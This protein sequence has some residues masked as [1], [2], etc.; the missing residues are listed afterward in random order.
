MFKRSLYFIIGFLALSAP[1]AVAAMAPIVSSDRILVIA[2]HPDD[3]MLGAGGLMQQAVAAGADLRVL[4]MTNGELNE[5]ASIFY[6]KRPLLIRS[7]FIKNGVIR[8]KEAVDALNFLGVPLDKLIFLGYPDG[9]TLNIWIKYW[10]NSKPFRSFFTRINKVPFKDNISYGRSYKGDEIIHDLERVLLDLRPTHIYVTGPFDL[11]T[12]HQAAYLYVHVAVLNLSDMLVPSP[13]IHL[14]VVHAHQ[15]PQPKKYVPDEPMAI[16][17]HIDWS[18]A[19]RWDSVLLESK[20]VEKKKDALLKYK[21]QTAY[22]KKFLLSF[23]RKSEVFA[24]YSHEVVARSAGVLTDVQVFDERS[25]T[26]DVRYKISG[27]ELW[28]EIPLTSAV[29]EMGVLS[30]YIFSYRKGFLFSEMPKLSFKLFGN[31][32]FVTNGH[33]NF[34]DP[35]VVYRF[36]GTRLLLRVPLKILKDPDHLFVSTRRAKEELSLDFGSWRILEVPTSA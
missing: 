28:V 26:G 4:Y 16:P 35:R 15:W 17:S 14:Y 7:D 32:M 23:A 18:D 33:K 25:K 13:Q 11:N 3:E 24:D 34:H 31:K 1:C 22:K 27:D 8:Q 5:V 30:S 21:S 29:D 12:D 20:Q 36:D 9:G 19:I 2:P 10:G 6:Q